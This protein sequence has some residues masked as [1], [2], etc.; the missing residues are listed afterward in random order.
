MV[1]KN[2]LFFVVVVCP[3]FL[4]VFVLYLFIIRFARRAHSFHARRRMLNE[5]KWC[6]FGVRA[7]VRVL[8]CIHTI[9]IIMTA[10][11]SLRHGSYLTLFIFVFI[12]HGG[13]TVSEHRLLPPSL[14]PSFHLDM[15]IVCGWAC[16][17][18]ISTAILTSHLNNHKSNDWAHYIHP[19]PP[20]VAAHWLI[21]RY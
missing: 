21:I 10:W 3:F 15:D 5:M 6:V 2:D 9:T 7:R 18:R 17:G 13:C 14:L 20:F 1:F 16:G 12:F 8:Y 11:G 19:D 4:L